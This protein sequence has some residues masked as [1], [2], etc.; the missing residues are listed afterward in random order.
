MN[1]EFLKYLIFLILGYL[2][3]RL[4]NNSTPLPKLPKLHPLNLKQPKETSGVLMDPT[5]KELK[6]TK[7]DKEY[8]R[9]VGNTIRKLFK[10]GLK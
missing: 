5:P 6:E 9:V 2:A 7:A 10:K 3:G 1:L 8:N 4:N